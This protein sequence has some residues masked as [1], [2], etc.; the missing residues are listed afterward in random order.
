MIAMDKKTGEISLPEQLVDK[1][2]ELVEVK[3]PTTIASGDRDI[4]TQLKSLMKNLVT[5]SDLKLI[6]AK[7]G[8]NAKF[9]WRVKTM[10]MTKELNASKL[11]E[12][13]ITKNSKMKYIEAAT[14]AEKQAYD[15]LKADYEFYKGLREDYQ[16]W[17]NT[18]K[19]LR[20]TQYS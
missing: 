17:I 7:M 13:A 19:H 11:E 15:E 3:D 14:A 5:I 20:R 8:R 9:L 10:E 16:E 18:Y 2:A 4:D 12:L 6:I 1:T